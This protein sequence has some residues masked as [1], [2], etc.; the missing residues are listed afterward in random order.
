MTASF[1]RHCGAS[2][3]P[4]QAFCRQ[5]GA[6]T[7]AGPNAAVLPG[8]PRV[9]PAAEDDLGRTCPYCRYPLKTGGP[10]ATCASCHATHHEDCWRENAGCAVSS[11][12]SGPAAAITQVQPPVT[13]AEQPAPFRLPPV[14]RPTATPIMP[15]APASSAGSVPPP[16][17]EARAASAGRVSGWQAALMALL[18]AAVLGGA[19]ILLTSGRSSSPT[20]A[21]R[22]AATSTTS[23]SASD[24][25]TTQSA[26]SSTDPGASTDTG[27]T[28]DATGTG[29]ASDPPTAVVNT[30]KRHFDLISAGDYAGAF[31]LFTPDF[32]QLQGRGAWIAAHENEAPISASVSMGPPTFS[33]STRANAPIDRLHITARG[34]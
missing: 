31:K 29:V 28:T 12:A 3:E 25:S 33:S 34:K 16:L 2:L 20:A 6:A 13:A 21:S 10:V 11:C 1:C 8:N 5:C 26:T 19:A 15:T 24:T 27:S 14:A 22:A 17:P 32:Q 30:V 18:V 9:R 4:S 23:G 7:A